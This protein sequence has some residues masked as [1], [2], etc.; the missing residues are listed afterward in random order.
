MD[1]RQNRREALLAMLAA[2]GLAAT[3]RRAWPQDIGPAGDSAPLQVLF[4]NTHLLPAIAQ[5]VAGHRGQD[6]Y[7]T[8]AMAAHLHHFDLVG[9]CEVFE[10]R[11]R[12]EIVRIVQENST[13][14]FHAIEPPK[15]WGRHLIGSGLLL[16]TR[17]AIES[18][19][20]FLTYRSASRVLTN[21]WKADGFAA[22][23]AIHARLC[24]GPEPGM[25]ADCFLTHL[26]S[27]S[28]TARAAQIAEL[29]TFV[30]THAS[31]ARPCLVMGDMNVAAE[32]PPALAA[33]GSEYRLLTDSLQLGGAPLVDLWPQLQAGRG[34]T[35]DALAREECRRIDYF[36]LS[37][38][39]RQAAVHWAP[40]GVRVEPY[41]DANV[42]Q[43]SL[44]DHAGVACELALRWN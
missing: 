41:L 38:P 22:K 35:R 21:G 18:D 19:P 11:R 1:N 36:F 7:R 3:A 10:S 37:P 5:S 44:S 15:V 20:H 34:G 2:G 33:A 43:G 17:L 14:A 6:D 12:R 9:L 4:F 8:A 26:E 25:L 23:G 16:L 24:L 27:V 28:A 31:P 40:L 29:A 32:H 30:A 39:L 42:K 13:Q